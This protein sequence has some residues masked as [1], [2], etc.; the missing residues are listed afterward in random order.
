MAQRLKIAGL[1]IHTG[2]MTYLGISYGVL[3]P[4]MKS[5]EICIIRYSVSSIKYFPHNDVY[6]TDKGSIPQKSTPN[7]V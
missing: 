2:L 5:L 4:K 6:F 7:C 3:D 1:E